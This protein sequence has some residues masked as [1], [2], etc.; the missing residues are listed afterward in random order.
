LQDAKFDSADSLIPLFIKQEGNRSPVQ[1]GT[2]IF[3]IQDSEPF[4]LTAAH[5]TDEALKENV[6]VPTPIGFEKIQGYMAYIDLLPEMKRSQDTVDVAY[7]RLSTDFANL[8]CSYFHPLSQSKRQIIKSSLELSVCSIAGFPVTKSKRKG[9]KLSSEFF[10]YRGVSAANETYEKLGLSPETSVIVHFNKKNSISPITGDRNLP[11]KPTG[12][13]GG[14]IFAWPIGSELS[15][16]WNIPK[17]VGVFH[18]YK[19]REGL[20][21]GSSLINVLAAIQ[22][23]RMKKFEGVV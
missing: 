5:V 22:L 2:A 14:G 8:L 12:V 6:I 19:E 16:D 3:V 15:E 7:F 13:S 17:L 11:P 1:F 4:L 18:T 10:A 9:E 20:L 21:I 23:G